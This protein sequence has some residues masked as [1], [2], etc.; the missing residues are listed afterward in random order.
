MPPDKQTKK[1]ENR[2]VNISIGIIAALLITVSLGT[3]IISKNTTAFPINEDADKSDD[4]QQVVARETYPS[5]EEINK[6]WPKF[7][8]P[9]GQGISLSTNAPIQW[10]A[11]SGKNIKWKTP[12]PELPGKNS[13]VVW[14]DKIL[15]SGGN[16]EKRRVYCYD[17]NTGK[18]LW[19]KPVAPRKPAG[20]EEPH[21][22][23]D[24]GY[25]APTMVT[26]GRR[27]YAIFANGDIAA[28]DFE[29]NETWSKHLGTPESVYGYAA[30]L[31][32][33]QDTVLIEYDV[34]PDDDDN[35]QSKLIA[36]DGKTGKYKWQKKRPVINSWT[37]PI[38]FDTPQGK[39]L[40]TC[41]EPFVISYDPTTGGEL[42][43]SECVY[44]D[45]AP[46]PV[47]G[48][49]LF[50]F[51]IPHE[52]LIAI[53]LNDKTKPEQKWTAE[54][55]IPDTASPLTNGELVWLLTSNGKVH[56]IDM[57]DGSSVWTTK[58]L[59]MEFQ[60]SPT[61]VGD[62]IYLMSNSTHG[63]TIII[64][65]G[66]EYREIGRNVLNDKIFASPAILDS[67][68]YIRGDKYL[69]CIEARAQRPQHGS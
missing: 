16:E 25:A 37:S 48:N 49:E 22:M 38:I 42:W 9:T 24:T 52:S 19:Q 12:V 10:D 68:I 69:Y 60:S 32:I 11:A 13:P 31:T 20:T 67:R 51:T 40:I 14:D 6:N 30:S 23:E 63:T 29:G 21:I 44:G 34:L 7:R 47:Y 57:K 15:F 59:G 46:S 41:A 18:E 39:Q 5:Q 1:P 66:R 43:R 26:D 35:P 45:L 27:A 28:F 8:G 62:K 61:L 17:T 56:C 50:L 33:Y 58:K 53:G 3:I 54:K 64:E 65:A 2:S 36:L 55:N 4:G